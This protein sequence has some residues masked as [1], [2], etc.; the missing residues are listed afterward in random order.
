MKKFYNRTKELE[1]LNSHYKITQDNTLITDVIMGRRRIGKTELIKKYLEKKKSVYFYVTQKSSHVLLADFT[2]LLKQHYKIVP[3]KINSWE[4]FFN[5]IFEISLKENL[6]IVFDEFQNFGEID[7]AIFSILQKKIDEYK[8]KVKLHLIFIGSIQTLM[9]KIFM[10]KKAL[11]GRVDN[12]IRLEGFDFLEIKKISQDH[13]LRDLRKIFNLYSIFNGIAKY[14]DILEKFD[15][16]KKPL[17]EILAKTV[18]GKNTPL[19]K[20]GENLLIEEFGREHK[21]YFD[22]LFYLSIGKVKTNEIAMEMNLP[23]T[24]ISKYLSVLLLEYK[25][26][27]KRSVKST[28]DNRYYI[29]D[30]FLKFWFSY[31]YGNYSKIEIDATDT[32][33]NNFEEDFRSMQGFVFEELARKLLYKKNLN[34]NFFPELT[35]S[36]YWDR[37]HE[38]DIYG[39]YK[40]DLIIGEIKLNQKAVNKKLIEKIEDFCNLQK[41]KNIFKV[42][43]SFEKIKN[44]QILEDLKNK[45][46]YIFD[47]KSLL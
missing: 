47:F 22:I 29:R 8:N 24:T 41:N 37:V 43:I 4:D 12:F 21:R 23:V 13:G 31:I 33:L 3:E 7:N 16:F 2:T 45:N 40:K 30:I 36:N 15:L 46:Y 25:L 6:V 18:I 10:E 38:F 5:I 32:I 17:K 28:R 19:Y 14:Y 11:F 35:L 39:Q 1:T 26:I 44:K 42:I 27:E 34:K 20:E 9:E